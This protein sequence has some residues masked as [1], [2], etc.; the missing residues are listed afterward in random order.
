MELFIMFALLALTITLDPT[1][2]HTVK[3][4]FGRE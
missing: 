3:C 4:V 1:A 2:I